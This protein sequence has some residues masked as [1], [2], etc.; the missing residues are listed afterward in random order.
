MLIGNYHSQL[1]KLMERL[2]RCLIEDRDQK[3]VMEVYSNGF[4]AQDTF[5]IFT[6]TV[7]IKPA[8]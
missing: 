6:I 3:N 7:L 8:T 2:F 4:T 5:F 1:T